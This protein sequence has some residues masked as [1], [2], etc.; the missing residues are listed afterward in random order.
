MSWAGLVDRIAMLAG[1]EPWYYD[2]KGERHETGLGTKVLVLSALKLDVTSISAA[3][4]SL[5]ALETDSWRRP[6]AP[7]AVER[8][9][10]PSL[11]LFGP[12]ED[13]AR[14]HKWRIAFESGDVAQGEF[15]PETLPLLGKREIDR[16]TIEHRRL[17]LK[18]MPEGYHRVL[19][20]GP[21]HWWE[22]EVAAC[23]DQCFVP[24]ALS[25]T[26]MRVWGI[27][28]HLY[29]L[30]SD[31]NWGIGDFSD[32]A[33]F[34][35]MIGKRGGAAVAVNPFHALFPGRPED[36][37]PYS[38]SSR[39]F[40]NPL[41]VDPGPGTKI[42]PAAALRNT[43]LVDYT[44]VSKA[45]TAVFAT[46]FKSAAANVAVSDFL[47]E[48]GQALQHFAAFCV[49][50]EVHGLPWRSWPAQYRRPDSPAIADFAREHSDRIAYH[51]FLQYLADS[52]LEA[53]AEEGQRAGLAIGLIRDL[54]LGISPDG[55]DA[56]S[57]QERFALDLRC[58]APP[59][60]FQPK[61]QEWGILPFDPLALARDP[62]PVAELLRAN[63]RHA[64][65][66]RI[67][68][69][70]G[71]QRQFLVPL[72]G[73]PKDGCYLRFPTDELF[74]LLALESARNQC[75]ILGEDLGTVPEGFRERMQ[76]L[77]VFGCDLLYFERL[78]GGAFK[79][80]GDYRR[81]AAVSIATHDLP[82]FAGYWEGRDIAWRRRLGIYDDAEARTAEAERERGRAKLL[83][84]LAAIGWTHPA[85]GIP[86]A[87]AELLK[88]VHAFLV[89]SSAQIFLAKLDDLFGVREQLNL[90]GTTTEYPNWRR[91]LPVSLNDPLFAKALDQL[92]VLC[93]PRSTSTRRDPASSTTKA[94]QGEPR[95]HGP[96]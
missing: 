96:G 75:L 66:L 85:G 31:R 54:A 94:L 16:R 82:T 4:A 67:D 91:K 47:A 44:A 53:A 84:A 60:D 38:P 76:A 90:P 30:R 25:K 45:K 1:I 15:K 50:A 77:N 65:G 89:S 80:P 73:E 55:V 2:L 21:E 61:G 92:A 79:P 10:S 20:A 63:M 81:K 69:V 22:G 74:G 7:F 5:A 71:L 14:V 68:H 62:K 59:D 78:N 32:L 37:S 18:P 19:L 95:V 13:A 41:Y 40:L 27:A 58:G 72:G 88:A 42:D 51:G 56:W 33:R 8:A 36:A 39:S 57:Q 64:G 87:D 83:E 9:L 70:I 6:L 35:A 3:E 52:Q 28:E 43:E 29:R 24:H 86:A 49:L 12:A 93:A 48:R 26:E 11:A 23:P 46:L 17:E 34:A